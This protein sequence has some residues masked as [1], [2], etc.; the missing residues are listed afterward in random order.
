MQKCRYIF[1][2]CDVTVFRL[3]GLFFN[4]LDGFLHVVNLVVHY[5]PICLDFIAW[6]GV[7]FLVLLMSL[8]FMI[9]FV[10]LSLTLGIFFLFD[11]VVFVVVPVAFVVIS[12]KLE[13]QFY[14]LPFFAFHQYCFFKYNFRVIKRITKSPRLCNMVSGP[15]GGIK[16]LFT[17]HI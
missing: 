7:V 8:L 11:T 10:L 9:L 15:T 14:F 13:N 17:G 4:F 1:P 16:F 5:V 12:N 6:Y 3:Y 2:F